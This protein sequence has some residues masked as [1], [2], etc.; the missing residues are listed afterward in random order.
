MRSSECQPSS[1]ELSRKQRFM[2]AT[3]KVTLALSVLSTP[4]GAATPHVVALGMATH[5]NM[6]A[7]I[8]SPGQTEQET[9]LG[10]AFDA[11]YRIEGTKVHCKPPEYINELWAMG[12]I[13]KHTKGVV[14]IGVPYTDNLW[15]PAE[16]CDNLE[17]FAEYP[18]SSPRDYKTAS[19]RKQTWAVAVAAHEAGHALDDTFS[20]SKAQC[21]AI[22]DSPA[23]ARGLG[24][25]PDT[26]NTVSDHVADM[27]QADLANAPAA[28]QFNPNKC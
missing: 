26:I 2:R 4:L 13:A 3:G 16:M 25:G 6:I 17:D 11:A 15:L 27:L 10:K 22:G 21:L 14:A 19:G 7:D 1:E 24:A 28:Y 9:R 8:V 20:E 23:L 5:H 12:A 18:P